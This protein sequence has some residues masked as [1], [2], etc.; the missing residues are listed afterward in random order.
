MSG[1]QRHEKEAFEGEGTRER[2]KA[3]K[4]SGRGV[5]RRH[6]YGQGIRKRRKA[7]VSGRGVRP[8][9]QGEA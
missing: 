1:R 6:T 5:R 7:K 8:R 2:R 9:H 3:K 4:A